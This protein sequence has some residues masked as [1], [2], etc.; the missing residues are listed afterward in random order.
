MLTYLRPGL[1]LLLSS[2][3]IALVYNHFIRDLN[4][5]S[6]LLC[7]GLLVL[8]IGGQLVF[9]RKF[10]LVYSIVFLLCLIT[11]TAILM[12]YDDQLFSGPA[13]YYSTN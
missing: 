1:Q 6:S 8:G 2:L 13:R 3:F 7:C 4:P 11:L 12:H 10:D 9:I 5:M